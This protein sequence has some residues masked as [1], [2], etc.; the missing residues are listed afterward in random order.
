MNRALVGTLAVSLSALSAEDLG[1]L[2]ELLNTD[3]LPMIC[4][5]FGHCLAEARAACRFI[6]VL[7]SI[8]VPEVVEA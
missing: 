6:P 8:Q 1:L 5:K 2:G 4:E 3:P 7:D